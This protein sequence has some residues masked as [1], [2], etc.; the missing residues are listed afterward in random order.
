LWIKEVFAYR[1]FYRSD[2]LYRFIRSYGQ[3][4]HR[5]DLKKQFT[6]IT[7]EFPEQD[8]IASLKKYQTQQSN[9]TTE[10]NTIH[11]Y[12]HGYYIP[13]QIHQKHLKFSCKTL[14]EAEEV[15]FP[16]LRSFHPSLFIMKSNLREYGWITPMLKRNKVKDGHVL[17]S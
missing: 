4:N 14:Q 2:I 3:N 13:L 1:Y 9:L 6:Y 16:K 10:K 12:E 15:L 11:L 7:K 8:L 5:K 17:Y